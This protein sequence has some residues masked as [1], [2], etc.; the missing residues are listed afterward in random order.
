MNQKSY[1]KK[2][3][4]KSNFEFSLELFFEAALKLLLFLVYLRILG[5]MGLLIFIILFLGL[6]TKFFPII[7]CVS[8]F[9]LEIVLLLT[10]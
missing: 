9:I 5:V 4:V 1:L 2:E 8:V 3:V 10:F 7:F 6:L